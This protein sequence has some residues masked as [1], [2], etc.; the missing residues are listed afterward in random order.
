MEPTFGARL[1]AQ[2]EQQ[3]ISLSR[4]SEET[5]IKVSMLEG[6]ERGDVS[7]WPEGIFRRAYVRAYARVVGLNPE[8][9][10][11]EFLD[12][13]PDPVIAPPEPATELEEPQWPAG[14]RRL[15]NSAIAAVPSRLQRAS[16]PPAAPADFR[17]EAPAEAPV[18][19]PSLTL[20]MH[21]EPEEPEDTGVAAEVPNRRPERRP[22][23]SLLAAAEL[24]TRLG[25]V[26]DRREVTPIMED[27]AMILDA[28]GLIVWTWDS[29]MAAL[30]PSLTYGYSSS[31]V[32][33]MPKVR[34]DEDNAIA[35]AFQSVRAC[36]VDRGDQTTGA[37]VVPL[38]AHGG[39]VGVLAVELQC[40][41]EQREDVLA[42]A[43]IL[44]AQLVTL[45][46]SAPLAEAVNA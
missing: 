36:V 18:P 17:G 30:K 22:E 10:V 13:H 29:R 19:Q 5:K 20:F 7:Q 45:V 8:E 2:R 26:I 40:G 27:A 12:A 35:I 34:L 39:C 44:A 32:A 41:D 23:L 3:Q 4:I 31:K 21:E 42:F 15:V 37:V 46:V 24:C 11:R 16:A 9:L 1:R 28:V 38:M 14:F 6:L 43:T 33:R 25:R